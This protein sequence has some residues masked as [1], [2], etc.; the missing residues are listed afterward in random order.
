MD[1]RDGTEVLYDALDFFEF[2]PL[3]NSVELPQDCAE[4][5]GE[6]VKQFAEYWDGYDGAV[7]GMFLLLQSAEKLAMDEPDEG[8]RLRL[9]E[10]LAVI[11]QFPRALVASG[12]GRL[13]VEEE[14]AA[15]RLLGSLSFD[16]GES[17]GE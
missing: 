14:D 3:V 17:E 1:E 13:S 16:G 9:L 8:V 6:M 12:F 4:Q 11:L 15:R 10:F 7:S 5:V 2:N